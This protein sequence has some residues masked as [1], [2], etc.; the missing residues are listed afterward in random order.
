MN[1]AREMVL[2]LEGD[3]AS[4]RDLLRLL[5]GAGYDVSRPDTCDDGLRAARE[6]GADLL[7][8]DEQFSGLECGDLLAELK[9]A[10]ATADMRVILLSSGAAG[11]RVRGLDLGADDVVTRPWE[12]TELLARVRTQLRAKKAQDDLRARLRIAEQGQEMSRTAFEALAVTEKMTRDA[13][14]LGR[15][16]KIGLGV[17]FVAVALMAGIYF[18]FSR[19]ATSETQRSY[20]LISRLNRNLASQ[21][22]LVERARK[23]SEQMQAYA[24][25]S[26]VA[27]KEQLQKQ[28][29]DLRAQ[30][31]QAS[32]DQAGALRGKLA[33]TQQRLRQVESESARAEDIIRTYAPSVCL[34]H[35]AIALHD[36]A[37]GRPLRYFGLTSDGEPIQDAKGNPII[38]LEGTGP[39]IRAEALGTAFLVGQDGQ[40]LTNHH[41]VEPWWHNEEFGDLKEQG[42]RPVIVEM[43][44]YFPGSSNPYPV[45]TER[46]SSE[47]DVA[48]VRASLGGLKR[49]VLRLDGS[50]GAAV[51]GEPIVLMGYATGL[52]AVLARADDSTVR[53][54][55]TSSNGDP[56]KILESLAQKALIRPLITQGHLGDVLR[57]KIVYDAQTTSGGSGGPVFNSEGKV[58][59]INYAI[60]EGFGGSNFG[61]PAQFAE[62]LLTAAR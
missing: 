52:D 13:F 55:V 16:L 38:T 20:A 33:Q 58:I 27:Q 54:V 44:A 50:K 46:I 41:V 37:S 60:L 15:G 62:R 25:S 56:E 48:L 8:L 24:A 51:N 2:V 34:I 18:R 57:D 26:G 22:E 7:L 1:E 23:L 3:E 12:T 29:E 59:G 47:A 5:E 14:S 43:T 11:A 40:L 39:E 53:S 35:V 31:A 42:V 21:E 32:S 17:L 9:G 30:M 45:T 49:E 61:I 19:S 6:K 36:E 10:S 28:S 4:R